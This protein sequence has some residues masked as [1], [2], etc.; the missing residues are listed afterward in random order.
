MTNVDNELT[1][2][3]QM[4]QGDRRAFEYFF[5]TYVDMLHAYALGYCRDSDV[6]ED[7]VQ[8]AFVR[9]WTMREKITY[10]E[11]IYGY[12]Q[13]TVRN[14]CINQK[15]RERVEER[16]RQEM[17]MTEADEEDNFEE[18]YARL[19]A[20]MDKL[21]PKCREIFILGCVESMSYKEIADQLNISINTVKTQMKVAYKKIKDELD[22]KNMKI[23]ALIFGLYPNKNPSRLSLYPIK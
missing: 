22:D 11:S 5:N 7:L 12:L 18:L 19:Q 13:R 10:S 15:V 2:F 1:V 23:M 3:L 16:Y 9:F 8:E 21:P 17:L 6:A 20:V 4:Q 14:T